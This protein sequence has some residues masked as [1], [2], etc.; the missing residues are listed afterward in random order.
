MVLR[1]LDDDRLPLH[2]WVLPCAT[3][4]VQQCERWSNAADYDL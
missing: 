2:T 1:G 4:T 3:P